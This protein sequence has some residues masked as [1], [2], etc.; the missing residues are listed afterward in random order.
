MPRGD[1]IR[2]SSLP[3]GVH[4]IHR[5]LLTEYLTTDR[6]RIGLYATDWRDLIDQVGAIMLQAGDIEASYIDAMKQVTEE[7]G[8]YSVIA[9][10]VVLLHGRPE[11]G[12]IR[13]C[14]AMVTLKQGI[15][16]GS[17]NDPVMLAI[18]MGAIDHTSHIEAI[19]DLANLL[20]DKEKIAK[21]VKEESVTDF[22]RI[23][24][25]G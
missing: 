21:L 8:P 9:P 13:I 1:L 25:S 10:G 4:G 5:M 20:S 19:K 11:D 14:F 23:L 24:T 12:V 17:V 18:G 2:A 6:I 16:F 3:A 7:M 15:S 22:M